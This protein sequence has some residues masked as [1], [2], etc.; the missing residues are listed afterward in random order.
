M[1]DLDGALA[2]A[3]TPATITDAVNGWVDYDFQPAGVAVAGNYIGFF[4]A[5]VGAEPDTYPSE[6]EGIEI[7]IFDPAAVRTPPV[8]GITTQ[9]F[10]DLAKSPRRTRTVEG[11]VEER[12]IDDLIK[13]DRYAKAADLTTVP[14]GIR[15]ART[16]PPGT[17]S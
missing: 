15:T 17:C 14:W 1:Y 5:Y 3:E 4:K 10:I 6:D 7:E 13:A 8:P 11:T 12:S 2:I 9:E 16:K